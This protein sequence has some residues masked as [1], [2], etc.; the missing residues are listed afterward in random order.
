MTTK[1]ERLAAATVSDP[2][3]AAICARDASADGQFVYSVRTT[4]VYCR[5]SCAARSARPENVEFHA[6]A[7]DAERAGF[8]TCRRCKPEQPARTE[9]HAAAIADLCRFI[10]R[11]ERAPTLDEL[12][13]R[14]GWSIWH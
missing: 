14:A 4:G 7:A 1:S 2:R 11:S 5:P 10:E 6:T 9:Q 3:W 13:E 12:A 8:R